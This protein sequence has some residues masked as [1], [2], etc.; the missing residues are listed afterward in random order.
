MRYA[1]NPRSGE[2]IDSEDNALSP[3]AIKLTRLVCGNCQAP[4]TLHVRKYGNHFQHSWATGTEACELYQPQRSSQP[5]PNQK[6]IRHIRPDWLPLSS[7]R[8][9]DIKL[10]LKDTNERVIVY[11]D[12]TL[13]PQ[14]ITSNKV[15]L[16]FPHRRDGQTTLTQTTDSKTFK[17]PLE[18]PFKH[19]SRFE[20]STSANSATIEFLKQLNTHLKSH[21]VFPL[22]NDGEDFSVITESQVFLED[23]DAI[24][25]AVD[26]DLR[27]ERSTAENRTTI[28]DRL[29]KDRYDV[30]T[31]KPTVFY[32]VTP[33]ATGVDHE[34]SLIKVASLDGILIHSNQEQIL[35][36]IFTGKYDSHFTTTVKVD[37]QL[38]E[39]EI[40]SEM[41][42]V[43]LI[44]QSEQRLDVMLDTQ[45]WG[46]ECIPTVKNSFEDKVQFTSPHETGI[47]S[48]KEN[49]WQISVTTSKN[50]KFVNKSQLAVLSMRQWNK[51]ILRNR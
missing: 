9:I 50:V 12:A 26:T 35:T 25:L 39:L 28:H 45:T 51:Q 47:A 19:L 13:K 8:E 7:G 46:G 36:A 6:R 10:G 5:T 24:L 14:P 48:L 27:V 2:D 33:N 29:S 34:E 11:A 20:T 3:L 18:F 15:Q 17:V 23:I 41:T 4:V 32:T 31:D 44:S 22:T 49:F 37:D 1:K 43:L 21:S 42:R 16:L 30:L 40:P 38:R